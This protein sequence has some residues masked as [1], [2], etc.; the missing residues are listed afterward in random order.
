MLAV[1]LLRIQYKIIFG[2]IK[3]KKEDEEEMQSE[4]LTKW[5]IFTELIIS[6]T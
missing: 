4:I 1:S 3:K 2:L 6:I 5:Q